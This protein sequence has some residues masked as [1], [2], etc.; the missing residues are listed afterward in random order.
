VTFPCT[1]NRTEVASQLVKDPSDIIL[2]DDFA[3]LPTLV[4][5]RACEMPQFKITRNA[6]CRL[7]IRGFVFKVDVKVGKFVLK[8]ENRR[9]L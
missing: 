1:K 3:I 9:V 4:K 5:K 2:F 7:S 8:N 6:V